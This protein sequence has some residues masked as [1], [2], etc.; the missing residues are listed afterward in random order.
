MENISEFLDHVL[1]PV[2]QQS[3]SYI[4]DSSDF[5]KKL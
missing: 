3:R 2:L 4:K 5:I 1:K